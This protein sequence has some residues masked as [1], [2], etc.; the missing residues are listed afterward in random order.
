MKA[1]LFLTLVAIASSQMQFNFLACLKDAE[2]LIKHTTTLIN[3][4]KGKKDI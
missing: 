3:D 4:I 1:L 2:T